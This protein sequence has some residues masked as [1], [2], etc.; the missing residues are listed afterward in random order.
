LPERDVHPAYPG[1]RAFSTIP[2]QCPFCYHA[3]P[4]GARFCNDCGSPLHLKPCKQ[5]EAINDQAARNCYKCGTEDPALVTAPEA[6]PD[7]GFEFG[8]PSLP[9]SAAE[10]H[11]VR[12]QRQ[13][14]A[15]A[16]DREPDVEVV[17]R[18][19]RSLD[20]EGSS[21]VSETPPATHVIPSDNF[22]ATAGR[23]PMSRAALAE[24]VPVVLLIA[25]A[26]SAYHVYR[27]PLQL[28]EWLSAIIAPA[29]EYPGG[30]RTQ[31]VPGTIGV[32]ASSA[33]PVDLGTG[34]VAGINSTGPAPPNK[35][36][37]DVTPSP[38]RQDGTLATGLDSAGGQTLA[39]DASRAAAATP[40][41][42]GSATE[43]APPPARLATQVEKGVGTSGVATAIA[44]EPRDSPAI[45]PPHAT[46]PGGC[47]EAI[48]ALG[49]C[50]SKKTSTN[51][52]TTAKKSK[53]TSTK[54]VASTQAPPAP[55][56][57][58]TAIETAKTAPRE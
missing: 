24:F 28:R 58:T 37:T 44:A 57:S 36:S 15:T 18:E 1:V 39:P 19:P 2:P 27:H 51:A 23:R 25:V 48:A 45:I 30:M 41:P 10:S 35:S 32:L 26:I 56:A 54:K 40:Q 55:K 11:D 12:S 21:L 46:R 5:C 9:Q 43:Q 3:N 47:T 31:S 20:E 6:A 29:D 13:G 49:P 4:A 38:V 52:K 17:T 50:S 22:G 33:P 42:L 34:S 8:H 16:I 53:K 7:V 14:N